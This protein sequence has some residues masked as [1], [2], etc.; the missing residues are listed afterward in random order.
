MLYMCSHCQDVVGLEGTLLPKDVKCPACGV[1]TP[2]VTV[3]RLATEL[4]QKQLQVHRQVRR[5]VVLTVMGVGVVLIFMLTATTP[6]PALSAL[7]LALVGNN[8]TNTTKPTPTVAKPEAT[9]YESEPRRELTRDNSP[10]ETPEPGT[11][12]LLGAGGVGL[13][14]YAWRRQRRV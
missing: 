5:R 6:K 11:L 7:W 8:D 12:V 9:R 3:R 1:A 10:Q 14:G 13:L 2:A 4:R